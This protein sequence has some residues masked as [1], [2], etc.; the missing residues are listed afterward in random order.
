MWLEGKKGARKMD[1]IIFS[2]PSL[3]VLSQIVQ[4]KVTKSNTAPKNA[5]VLLAK[6][7]KFQPS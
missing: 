1:Q 7:S 5:I 6:G 4:K 3:H 2:Y